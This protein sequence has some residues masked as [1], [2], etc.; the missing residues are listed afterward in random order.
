MFSSMYDRAGALYCS[1]YFNPVWHA[2][3]LAHPEPSLGMAFFRVDTGK[4][5]NLVLGS[6]SL[7]YEA[8]GKVRV[9]AMV[10]YWTQF[11]LRPLHDWIFSIIRL[12]PSDATFDQQGSLERFVRRGSTTYFCYDLSSATDMIPTLVYRSILSPVIGLEMANLWLSILVDRNFRFNV[13]K[14]DAFEGSNCVRYTRGQPMGALSSWASL[15][16]GH[17]YLVFVAAMSTGN[18][19]HNE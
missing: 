18:F 6:L 15:A 1:D 12:L 19:T 9:F 2:K 8:A 13:S 10:D 11:A 5:V 14:R 4:W 7:K 3:V 17:H 16:L